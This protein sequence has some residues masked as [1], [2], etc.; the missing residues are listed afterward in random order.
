M[1]E[2]LTEI[3]KIPPVTRFLV[4]SSL[5][6]TL[7]AILH[8]VSPWRLVFV[9]QAVIKDFEVRP[10]LVLIYVAKDLSMSLTV[11]D[12]I[13]SSGDCTQVASSEVSILSLWNM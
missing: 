10:M 7:P 5:G 8:L 11:L 6:I 4:A 9:S 2:I 1:A 13:H 12:T 3:R